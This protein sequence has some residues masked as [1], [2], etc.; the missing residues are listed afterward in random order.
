[1]FQQQ[2]LISIEDRENFERRILSHLRPACF[3]IQYNLSLGIYSLENVVQENNHA[4]LIQLMKELIIPIENWL[5]KAFPYD[6][7]ELLSYY[8]G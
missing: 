4:I 1:A 6:E 2:T 3:R 5:G 7:L 8:F